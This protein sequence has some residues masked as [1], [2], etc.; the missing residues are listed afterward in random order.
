M[1]QP[2]VPLREEIMEDLAGDAHTHQPGSP[3]H[4]LR[5]DP[6]EGTTLISINIYQ[7]C[8]INPYAF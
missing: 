4:H 2:F 6:W 1:F 7:H 8:I 3:S 5:R